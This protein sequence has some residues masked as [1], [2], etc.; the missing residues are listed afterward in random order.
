MNCAEASPRAAGFGGPQ[1][2]R[3][4]R[5]HGGGILSSPGADRIGADGGQFARRPVRQCAQ[6]Q[7]LATGWGR[8]QG[9]NGPLAPAEPQPQE[10]PGHGHGKN[11]RRGDRQREHYRKPAGRGVQVVAGAGDVKGGLACGGDG[12]AERVAHHRDTLGVLARGRQVAGNPVRADFDLAAG[13][14][15]Y[16]DGV[17]HGEADEHP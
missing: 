4:Q 14:A 3:G 6:R 11:R 15:D 10:Q 7:Q 5:T 2:E 12:V 1:L 17:V 8:R 13:L 16:R 9:G